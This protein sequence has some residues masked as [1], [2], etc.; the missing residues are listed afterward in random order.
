MVDDCKPEKDNFKNVNS[1][2]E[3]LL[4]L[5]VGAN[6]TVPP[7]QRFCQNFCDPRAGGLEVMVT[8]Q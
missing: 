6:V 2:D 1:W 7:D 4:L 5:M 8:L 3:M